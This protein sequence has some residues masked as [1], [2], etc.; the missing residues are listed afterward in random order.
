VTL[1][2][3][4]RGSPGSRKQ[5]VFPRACYNQS[6]R[7]KRATPEELLQ[8]AMLARTTT[9]RAR[10]AQAGLAFP[11]LDRTTQAMLLRQLYL[12]HF[13]RR[14][15]R[16]AH[17]L[18]LQAIELDVLPD[19]IHQDAARAAAAAGDVD[20]AVGHLRTAAKRSPASRRAFHYWTLG[21]TL[22]LAHRYK[23]AI[24]ALTIAARGRGT[25]APLYKAHLALARIA[26]G[27][28]A[29]DLETTIHAL[30]ASPSG[31]GYGRF[32]LGHLLYAAGEW[33]AATRCLTTFV[34][35]LEKGRT[36]MGI[37][38]EGELRMSRATLAKMERQ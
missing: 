5:G 8:K 35:R 25:S 23:P 29:P 1:W 31:T 32:V 18:A 13:E 16:K 10:Y 9:S 7:A 15:F 24:V 6:V 33:K 27:E 2:A 14:R 26:G 22:F 34:E 20:A 36:A 28:P 3:S 38:L 30:A 4:S 17:D 12:S 21:S 11:E 37:A 19:V